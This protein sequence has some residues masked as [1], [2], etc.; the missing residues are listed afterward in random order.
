MTPY[1]IAI[2][3]P[4]GSGKS[5]FAQ[6]LHEQVKARLPALDLSLITED[7]YYRDQAQVP[8]PERDRVNYDHPDAL[9]HDLLIKHL[10]CLRDG[11]AVDVPVY[12]YAVHTRA[13][14]VVH[15]SP[16]PVIVVEGILLLTNEQL[17][18]CFDVCFYLDAPLD[19]CLVRRLERDT[20]ER[21]RSLES[22]L[23]Q[24]RETVR[25][26]YHRFIKPSAEHADMVITGGGKNQ[27]ALDVI[28]SLVVDRA[29]AS[30]EQSRC[31]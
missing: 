9:E 15:V 14:D 2:A 7:A 6:L 26:M 10:G 17:R 11:H 4:S 23:A 24:Y 5:L 3:G 13:P 27:A 22:V 29:T 8:L 28:R 12:D 30:E 25:P 21:G 18:N 31:Q 19:V 20:R 16:T 1:L